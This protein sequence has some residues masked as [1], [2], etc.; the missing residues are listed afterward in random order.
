MK[1]WLKK[2]SALTLSAGLMVGLSSVGHAQEV[3]P[4]KPAVASHP[5][6][7]KSAATSTYKSGHTP[8]QL[9]TAYGVNSLSQT[10]VG[11]TIAIVDA[12]GS[13]TITQDLNTFN[14]QFG[15][16]A[17]NLQVVYPSGQPS[18][19]DGGWA[20]ETAMDVEWAHA[21]APD[22][23]I[24]VVGAKS[25]SITDLLAA[26]KYATDNG[27]T[28]VSNSWGGSESS[29]DPS[30]ESYF[31]K[32]GV[33]YVASSGD[34]GAGSSWPAVSPN[35]LAVGGTTLNIDS[36]GNYQ[37]ES[38]WSGSGGALSSY[39]TR[40]S[41]Q[42]GWQSVVST[43]RGFPDVSFDADPNTGVAVYSSTRDQ[44]QS[45]WFVV[46]GT[47]L[48]SPSV[49]GIIALADQGRTTPLSSSQVLNTVYSTAGTTGSS[50]YS[51]NFHDITSGNNV[52]YTATTGYDLVTGIGSMQANKFVSVLNTAN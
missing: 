46:G 40:P 17:A 11:Q 44:G 28:V 6:H 10:G 24:L 31:S 3:T 49:A 43:H 33:T 41:Y 48:G 12:Y 26:E 32:P 29:S 4:K 18:K 45:G 34:N 9:R 20:L 50:G 47:S 37:S 14:S 51:T 15:L 16:K 2:A 38:G 13:P 21:M 25:A 36:S 8:A 19:T 7:I 27:A 42:D 35:V 52:G 30:Y 1:E 22:A 39:F 23:K 5:I